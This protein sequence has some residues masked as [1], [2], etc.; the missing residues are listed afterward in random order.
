MQIYY[1]STYNYNHFY[2]A[3]KQ[4]VY[5]YMSSDFKTVLSMATPETYRFC[6]VPMMNLCSA[7]SRNCC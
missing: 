2:E 7:I 4:K 5:P 6:N 1:L 3:A